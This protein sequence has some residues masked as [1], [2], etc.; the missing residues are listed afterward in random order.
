ML[1]FWLRLRVDRPGRRPVRLFLPVILAWVL[2]FALLLVA[3]PVLLVA[4]L[5]TPAGPGFRLLMIYPMTFALLSRLSGLTL[6]VG[7]PGRG[8]RLE[9]R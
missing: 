3:L 4:A 2:V 9:F 1:P 8:V 6:D 5:L 7:A